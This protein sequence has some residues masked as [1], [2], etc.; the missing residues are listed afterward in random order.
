VGYGGMMEEIIQATLLELREIL[1]Q[2]EIFF[3][4]RWS[5]D[6]R[7]ILSGLC[8]GISVILIFDHNVKAVLHD[9]CVYNSKTLEYTWDIADPTFNVNEI[10]K[11]INKF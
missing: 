1:N 10:A 2:K 4:E 9:P 5:G 3:Q 7:T 8:L 6:N 11:F